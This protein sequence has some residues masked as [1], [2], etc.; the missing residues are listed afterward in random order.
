MTSNFSYLPFSRLQR[1]RVNPVIGRWRHFYLIHNIILHSPSI[2][3][4]SLSRRLPFHRYHLIGSATRR[5]AATACIEMMRGELPLVAGLGPVVHHGRYQS[6]GSTRHPNLIEH[7]VGHSDAR[8][9]GHY[10]N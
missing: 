2:R 8:S 5:D 9:S 3:Y 4:Y 10:H 7:Q 1:D 6:H